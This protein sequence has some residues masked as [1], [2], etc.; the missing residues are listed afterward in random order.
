MLNIYLRSAFRSI[1]KRK[2]NTL[3]SVIGL[4]IGFASFII[5]S[6]FIKYELDWD[7][8]NTNYKRVYRI[9]TYKTQTDEQFTQATP[10][11]YEFIKN[12][13]SD[14]E[15]QAVVHHNQ[16]VY[17][18]VADSALSIKATGQY[19]DQA[20]IEIFSYD[21]L[22]GSKTDALNEPF[23]IAISASLAETLYGDE[24]P[25]GATLLLDKKYPLKIT[26]VYNDLPLTA[27]LRP[28]FVISI[29]SLK[30]LWNSNPFENWNQGGFYVYVLV[31]EGADIQKIDESIKDIL[32]DKVTTDYRQLYLRPLSTLY[33][34]S[35]NNN[36]TIILYLLGVF[37]V[38]VLIL[39]AINFMNISIASSTLRAR[40]IGIK[41]V[42]GSSRKQLVIQIF[43]ET[44]AITILALLVSL[45]LVELTLG[46]FNE[47]LHKSMAFS[48]LFH[49]KFYFLVVS[50]ILSVSILSSIYPAWL[51]TSV[52]SLSLFKK[53]V[54][55]GK[56][57]GIDLK[58]F[59]VTFQFVIS[60]A[61]ITLAI[62]FSRQIQYMHTKQLGYN[63][64]NLLFLELTSSRNDVNYR[65][66]KNRFDQIAGVKSMSISRGFPINSGKYTSGLMLNREGGSREELI[67]VTT[68]WVSDDFV[69]TMEMEIVKGR[70]FSSDFS[71][72]ATSSCLI[73]ETAAQQFGW[74]DPV[75][76]YINDRKWQVVGVFKDMHFQD[77]YNQIKPLVLTLKA[78]DSIISGHI[79]VAFRTEAGVANNLKT[80]IEHIIQ[81]HFPNDPFE[82]VLFADHFSNDEIFTVFDSI[83]NII[84]FLSFVAVALSVFGVIGLVNH[85]LNQRTK[86]IAI[87][88]VNGCSSFT[89]FRSLIMEYVIIIFI[90]SGFG[91]FASKYIFSLLPLNYPIQQHISDYLIGVFF[92]LMVTLLAIFYKTLRESTRNPV[93]SLRYE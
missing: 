60:I 41:K 30:T 51:I 59:L 53:N 58:K 89:M 36:Y 92:A 23:T 12:K 73:N 11:V 65:M 14:I 82:L 46:M 84:K 54:F 3:I 57:H 37:S 28:D 35:T 4:S 32:K 31:K 79:Y 88:K 25:V 19:A 26:A 72:D 21:I 33:M 1:Q 87:R 47:K 15:N 16:E 55:A 78:D 40:E 50:I 56:R 81:E 62:L 13:Y 69:K 5:I 71:A 9:Q 29:I 80:H 77:M 70:G 7:K 6:L 42:I 85:S 24:D 90:A 86:E 66:I 83:D 20:S 38:F 63:K 76:K 18:S 93:D 68:F 22:S 67:D 52:S 45:V 27:H 61:L 49:E 34:Y 10:A 8:F 43:I 64:E 17:L 74:D 91:A 48:D 39:A 2:T 44:F 75:G